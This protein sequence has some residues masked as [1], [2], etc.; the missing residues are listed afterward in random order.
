MEKRKIMIDPRKH[1]L[2]SFVQRVLVFRLTV[3][4]LVISFIIG[5]SVFLVERNKV[6]E[7]V[8]DFALQANSFFNY[9]NLH[10]FDVPG[11]PDHEAILRALQD[12]ISSNAGLKT[13]R[14]VLLRLYRT[15]LTMITEIIDKDYS[16]IKTVKTLADTFENQVPR[17]KDDLYDII[18]VDGI[19]HVKVL[20]PL[21]N[22]TGDV[23]AFI[24]GVF[25]LSPK[26]LGGI[27]GRAVRTMLITIAVV[28]FT[29]V[30]LFPVI[31][32]L[33]HKLVAFST[34]LL[35]SNL[36]TLETLGSAIAQRD[37]DTNT[38]NYRVTIYSVRIAEAAGLSTRII[39]TLI[40]GAFLHDVGKIGI[41]DSIL[42]KPGR[43]TEDEFEVMKTH[44]S[45]GHEIVKRSLWL[46]DALE[47]VGYHHE[48]VNGRGYPEGLKGEE[49][50]I[51]ARIFAIA[52]VFDALT[53][54][55]PYKEAF[56]FDKAMSI[57]EESRGSH[58]D[59]ELLDAFAGIARPLYDQLA[60]RDDE[61]REDLEAIIRQY[62]TE[63][64]DSLDY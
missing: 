19:P 1:S 35:D 45:R 2:K 58:F 8:V 38:H 40:K 23:V 47:V 34:K 49:I 16:S 43:L 53:S 50:P 44:V 32:N 14:F 15:D 7:E 12:F 25:A 36:E 5:L 28:L 60:N 54:R 22:T 9:Q 24:K 20:T 39:Q 55:R 4:G 10:L 52:D 33:A 62:F 37:S 48:K 6:S 26:T 3:A 31:I 29:T 27:R 51:S 56:S 13:G 46:R 30:L 61:P 17:N 42:L 41:S 63:S 21:F 11:L 57:L 18:R 64:I 59:P